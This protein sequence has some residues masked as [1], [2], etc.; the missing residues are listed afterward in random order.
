MCNLKLH[1]NIYNTQP[2]K[3]NAC[4]YM[5]YLMI[6]HIWGICLNQVSNECLSYYNDKSRKTNEDMNNLL[7]W[8]AKK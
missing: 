1:L 3:L 4:M 5:S 7:E 2:N 8:D 6:Y